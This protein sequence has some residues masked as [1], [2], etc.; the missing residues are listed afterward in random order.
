MAGLTPAT[1]PL[2]VGAE[3]I[4]RAYAQVLFS[5]GRLS[6]ALLLAATLTAPQVGLSGLIAVAAAI[7]ASRVLRLPEA[8]V[9]DGLLSYNAL[10]VGLGIGALHPLGISWLALLIVSAAASVLLTAALRALISVPYALPIFTLPFL[11]VFWLVL[12]Q[13]PAA[14]PPVLPAST[15]A[16]AALG[17]LFFVPR[18]LAGA[19]VLLA[20]AVHSR[21][22]ALLA[23]A[24]LGLAASLA[25]LS[26]ALAD[27]A[28]RQVLGFNVALVVLALGGVFF[29][30]SPSALALGLFGGVLAA[31]LTVGAAPLAARLGLPLLVL[32]FNLVVLTT[33]LAMRQRVADGAPK[34]VDFLVGS[35]EENL[36]HHHTRVARFGARYAVRFHAPFL[37]A[38]TCTQGTHGPHTHRDLWAHAADFEVVGADERVYREDGSKREHYHCWRLPVLAV[39]DGVVVR[40]VDGIPDNAIGAIDAERNWGNLVVVRH[41]PGVHSLVAHLAQGSVT[42]REGQVVRRGDVLGRCGASGRAPTPHLHLQL[43]V[44]AM[45]G[46]ATSALELHDV[47]REGDGGPRWVATLTPARGER[48]RNVAPDGALVAGLSP[49]PSGTW[50]FEIGGRTEVVRVVIDLAGATWLRTDRDAALSWDLRD[51]VFTIYDALGP[52]DSVLHLLHAAIPRVPLERLDGLTW[53]D[54]LPLRR[55]LPPAPGALLDPLW[56]LLGPPGLEVRYRLRLDGAQVVVE[57]ASARLGRDG[58]P[59]LATRAELAADGPERITLTVRGRTLVAT[60]QRVESP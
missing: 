28:L 34:S 55:F 40:V 6:G 58:G 12:L 20:L 41:A 30:P 45:P 33:L 56:A 32:P 24:G 49:P 17:A 44:S 8:S 14:P 22:G 15:G 27:P 31:L 25:G 23:L 60:R 4:L 51:G 9:R 5:R 52:R 13:P 46:D 29:V 16:L 26:P 7:A 36:H 21:I 10:L 37:G 2:R 54:H 39:A 47:I 43:Q 35:P 11:A 3:A 18:P 1:H 19:L 50:R 53:T 42:A 48:L 57:G 59:W 38:W